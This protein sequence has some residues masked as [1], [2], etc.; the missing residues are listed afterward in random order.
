MMNYL[1]LD[2]SSLSRDGALWTAREIAQQP[3][4]WIRT[5]QLVREHAAAIADYLRLGYIP[6]VGDHVE[7]DGRRYTVLE[8]DRNRIA[9]ARIE[10]LAPQPAAPA[11]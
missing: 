8:M 11:S 4:S 6:R 5:Q 1:Q 10:R 9:R 3:E 7:Y 2:E